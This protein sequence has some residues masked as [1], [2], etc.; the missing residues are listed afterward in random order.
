MPS[1]RK[2]RTQPRARI[3]LWARWICVFVCVLLL[4]NIHDVLVVFLPPGLRCVGHA[5]T[6][7]VSPLSWTPRHVSVDKRGLYGGSSIRMARTCKEL[8]ARSARARH[9]RGSMGMGYAHTPI[10]ASRSWSRVA[11]GCES[12]PWL[13][14]SVYFMSPFFRQ[15]CFAKSCPLFLRPR[16]RARSGHGLH[17]T[18]LDTSFVCSLVASFLG[19]LIGCERTQR[20]E[21]LRL[22]V[23]SQDRRGILTGLAGRWGERNGYMCGLCFSSSFLYCTNMSRGQ[24]WSRLKYTMRCGEGLLGRWVPSARGGIICEEANIRVLRE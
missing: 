22:R 18:V 16:K 2:L 8:D 12:L 6:L 4:T 23:A 3:F 9:R 13:S 11:A 19:T 7:C 20:L 14:I 24:G 15:P 1:P 5:S 21:V 10:R 17:A